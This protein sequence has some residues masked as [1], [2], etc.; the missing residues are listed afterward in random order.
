MRLI[1]TEE[2]KLIS[3]HT[4]E[5]ATA[6]PSK[7]SRT[8][9]SVYTYDKD[10]VE[11]KEVQSKNNKTNKRK[12]EI[13]AFSVELSKFKL[14]YSNLI[15]QKPK[16]K[17]DRKKILE[18]ASYV[19][20]DEG[21]KESLFQSKE[22]PEEKLTEQ[23]DIPKKFIKKNKTYLIAFSLLLNGPYTELKRYLLEGMV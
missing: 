10:N 16:S 6:I 21:A 8:K 12:A 4:I 15:S 3:E 23:L 14:S 20:K 2:G 11:E 18:I 5:R 22:L 13:I 1:E 7:L 17:E 9:S 19:S